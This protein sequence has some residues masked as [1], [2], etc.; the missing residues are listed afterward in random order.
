MMK[1]MTAYL[2]LMAV[3]HDGTSCCKFLL[4]LEAVSV[5]SDLS[6]EC[7]KVAAERIHPGD[8]ESTGHDVYD[9]PLLR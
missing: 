8:C 7:Q 5:T 1:V 4:L 6:T 3:S 9:G 2:D